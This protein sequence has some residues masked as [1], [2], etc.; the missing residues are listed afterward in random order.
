MAVSGIPEETPDHAKR[1]ALAVL[2]IKTEM[3]SFKTSDGT[4]VHFRI[5]IECGQVVAGVIGNK[6]FIYD[7]WSDAVNTASRMESSGVA[8]KIQVTENFKNE[9]ETHS[10]NW[11]F[12]ERGNVNIKGKGE[13]KT[14]FLVN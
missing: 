2:D 12:E 5:G 11:N 10:G 8:G 9:L 6:K 3:E 4:E 14:Y 13:M 7:L 1:A